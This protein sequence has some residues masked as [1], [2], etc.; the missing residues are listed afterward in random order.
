M[1][2]GTPGNIACM[3]MTLNHLVCG[4]DKGRLAIFDPSDG[5]LVREAF[6]AASGP[7]LHVIPSPDC[8]RCARKPVMKEG[9]D[10]KRGMLLGAV[11]CSCPVIP[12][13]RQ[14]ALRCTSWTA[15]LDALLGWHSFVMSSWLGG[16]LLPWRASLPNSY[17]LGD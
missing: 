6:H 12:K 4:S 14:P 8:S 3:A 7:L 10:G 5:H 1:L 16:G 13:P 11:Q 17:L 2:E 9:M 15:R